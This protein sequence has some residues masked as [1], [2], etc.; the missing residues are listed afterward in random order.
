MTRRIYFAFHY[1][2]VIDFRANVVRN[3]CMTKP[4]REAA[5]FF[6]ASL[7]ENANEHGDI[8]IKRL[9]AGIDVTSTTSV[10]I[11]SYTFNPRWVSYEIMRSFK[12]IIGQLL[13]A[14]LVLFRTNLLYSWLE[15]D[16]FL[17][18]DQTGSKQ[19]MKAEKY[20]AAC[21]QLRQQPVWRLLASD[22]GPV[23]VGL[24]QAHLLE[25]E[26]RLPASVL[27]ERINR[28][29]EELRARGEDLPQTAQAYVS[30]WLRQGYLERRFL[31]G[32]AEEEY[33]LTAP[34]TTAIRFIAGL[35]EPRTA[36]TE[37]RLAVVIQQLAKLAEETDPDPES[38]VGS[39]L[40][41][42][43]RLDLEIEK[44][45]GGTIET[46]TDA[47]A[48]ERIR[49]II[50]LA[51][52]LASDFR[53][54]RNDFERLNRGLRECLMDDETGRGEVLERLF[55]GV[56]VIAESD[57][58]R[59]FSAFWRLLTDPGQSA[60]L[61]DSLDQ[62]M[63]RRFASQLPVKDRRFLLGLTRTLLAQGGLVHEVLQQFAAS[64]RS[65]VQSREYLEQRRISQLLKEAQRA[66]L[67]LKDEIR[68]TETLAYTLP[69]TSSRLTSVSQ[70]S[71]YDPSLEAP[72]EPMR[73]AD[74]PGI[75][76]ESVADLVAQSEIDFRALKA[77]I[78]A[79][80][81]E[82]PQASVADV[83][84]RHPAS[85][86]LGS[87]VGYLALGSRYGVLAGGNEIVQWTGGDDEHRRAKIPAIYF[88]RTRVHELV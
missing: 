49:E 56:D 7:W 18:S 1:Q 59:T 79:V 62:V 22:N 37:S 53:H 31:P 15:S 58:G 83:L 46:L 73:D 69:L 68:A 32:A 57:A 14:K 85:Q 47:Q 11:E 16:L 13:A 75:G 8:A 17:A 76:L 2:D 39:L 10:L 38:R 34:A 87:V 29:L 20:I 40:A 70:W 60:S 9:N 21:R 28:D 43:Q 36:A 82:R 50:T 64:L 86:G 88:L 12:R 23:V 35:A 65:F 6:N 41:E 74:I 72:P 30:D 4:H 44:I 67:S 27:H 19:T 78:R 33:E 71:L 61:D 54:V 77:N 3:H 26:H 51:D 55:A 45:R 52:S 48:I 81:Q 25:S 84:D 66:A 80:L 24:L 5:G 63:S 42:R